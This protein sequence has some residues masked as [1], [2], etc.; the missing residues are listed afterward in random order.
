MGSEIKAG[1]LKSDR[2]IE[3]ALDE[4]NPVSS[5]VRKVVRMHLADMERISEPDFPFYF[6]EEEAER[7]IRIFGNFQFA[8]G[9]WSKQFFDL[10][11]WQAFILW[12]AYGWK[13]KDNHHRRFNQI[14]IKVARKNGKTEFLSGIGIFGQFFDRYEKD[15]EIYWFATKKDQAAIGFERQKTMNSLLCQHSPKFATKSRSIQYRILGREDKSFTAYLGQDSKTEDGLNPFY[16]LCDEYHAHKTDGMLNVIESGMGARRCP[17]TWIIT[18]AGANTDGPCFQFEQYCKQ[19]LDGVT[20]LHGVLP[21][22]YDL[23]H[24][25]D[26]RD[27]NN[28]SKP[29]PGLG[30]SVSIEYLRSE[31]IKATTQGKAKEMNFK[32]KNLNIWIKSETPWL[33]NEIW[34]DNAGEQTPAELM[35]SLK[36]RLCFGGLDLA[37]VSDLSVL[38]LCF[39]P[40]EEGERVKFLFFAFCAND[41]A[42]RRHELDAVPYLQWADLGY[43][44]LTP[45]NVTDFNF[46][47]AKILELAALF[48]IHS[49][50]YDPY[51][52]THI[53]TDLIDEGVEMEKYAQNVSTMSPMIKL[54]ERAALNRELA[55][56]NNPVLLWCL[57]NVQMINKVNGNVMLGK[58]NDGAKI[59]AVTAMVISYGQWQE[60]LDATDSD[61][62]FAVL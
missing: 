22:I 38:S 13:R 43:L 39:P 25:D 51:A 61:I 18:T 55:H 17:M 50:G 3:Y 12:C 32:T 49:I 30:K 26:W 20:E 8:K 2:Y 48:N 52:A 15:A 35:E 53:T 34:R 46:I 59:D 28:W 40:K 9:R 58:P 21:F 45:G 7:V 44:I 6:D 37:M 47:K 1:R 23:D 5:W 27:E 31:F 60:H 54:V 14:Y 24:D 42:M 36:G 33:S 16:G 29:N 62:L 4:A 10:D 11:D 19:G 41:T 56:G 57:S